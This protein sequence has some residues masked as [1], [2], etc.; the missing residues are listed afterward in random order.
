MRILCP[1]ANTKAGRYLT[2]KGSQN[3]PQRDAA[4]PAPRAPKPKPVLPPGKAAR[5]GGG[6]N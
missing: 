4:A 5:D 2:H 6:D 1:P 3:D